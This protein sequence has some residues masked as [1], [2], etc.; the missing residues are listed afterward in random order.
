MAYPGGPLTPLKLGHL[1]GTGLLLA[2]ATTSAKPGGVGPPHTAG[3]PL[4]NTQKT[5]APLKWLT[6]L[7][8]VLCLAAVVAVGLSIARFFDPTN[9][10]AMFSGAALPY[11]A[12]A[13][14][15]FGVV[16][17]GF[18]RKR[19]WTRGL[20]VG[21]WVLAS[22][23]ICVYALQTPAAG[24]LDTVVTIAAIVMYGVSDAALILY[25]YGHRAVRHY[26]QSL[27]AAEKEQRAATQAS[28]EPPAKTPAD[29]KAPGP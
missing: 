1:T 23:G 9:A 19:S 13:A 4:S 12:A 15:G 22:I 17:Y 20:L 14:L 28:A 26:Y 21:V 7:S 24:T 18:V 2:C 8:V 25:F 11:F 29:P 16:G 3:Y 10:P 6:A 5:P 27:K